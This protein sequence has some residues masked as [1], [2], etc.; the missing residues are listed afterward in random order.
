MGE[1]FI[2]FI[3]A[4]F[5]I[6]LVISSLIHLDNLGGFS[7]RYNSSRQTDSETSETGEEK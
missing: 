1:L 6:L 7:E 2:D 3:L 4:I 5:W